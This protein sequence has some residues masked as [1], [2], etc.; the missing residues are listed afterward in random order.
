MAKAEGKRLNARQEKFI[1]GILDGKTQAQA[2]IDAGYKP[3]GADANAA[4][5]IRND[6]IRGEVQRRLDEVKEQARIYLEQQSLEMAKVIVGLAND[7]D[8]TKFCNL[9][10]AKDV[11]DRIGLKAVEEIKHT[12][13]LTHVFKG[14]DIESYPEQ[15]EK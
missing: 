15:D 1:Q 5:L 13:E 2:Y 12:G 14:M 11:L 6:R 8:P 10:A 4:R 7:G 3:K 9:Y